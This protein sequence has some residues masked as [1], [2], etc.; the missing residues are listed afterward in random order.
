MIYVVGTVALDT[1][2]YCS[3]MPRPNCSAPLRAFRC[4]YGGTGGNTASVLGAMGAKASL[5]AVVGSDFPGS[6][7]EKSLNA[8]G[9]STR[10]VFAREGALTSRSFA[11]VDGRGRLVFYF[12]PQEGAGRMPVPTLPLGKGDFIHIA[13]GD[14]EFNR[15]LAAAHPGARISF[16]PGYDVWK[17]SREDFEFLFSRTEILS[18]NRT[19]LAAVL[20]AVGK[21]GAKS[22]FS[23]GIK[24]LVVTCGARGSTV[25]S[26]LGERHRVKSYTRSVMVDPI[27]AGDAYRAGFLAAYARGLPLIEC[28]KIASSA[29]SFVKEQPGGQSGRISWARVSSRAKSL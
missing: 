22:L 1:I 28:A 25:C 10:H 17:Y 20:K 16:D 23:Y 12:E 15:A 7:Y 5:I 2:L 21:K 26:R 19:E 3:R 27:G 18:M 13:T 11:P 4:V 29:A 6:P 9:V 14:H 8:K 24:V